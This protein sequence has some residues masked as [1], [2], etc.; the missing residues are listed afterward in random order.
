LHE[1]SNLAKTVRDH[2]NFDSRISPQEGEREVIFP[3][4]FTKEWRSHVSP[5]SGRSRIPGASDDAMELNDEGQRKFNEIFGASG[6]TLI[7]FDSAGADGHDGHGASRLASSLAADAGFFRI[8]REES[9]VAPIPATAAPQASEAFIPLGTAPVATGNATVNE[10][11]VAAVD[12]WKARR[13]IEEETARVVTAAREDAVKSGL[14]EGRKAGYD[15]GY[16]EGFKIGEEK[17][18]ISSRQVAG[19]FFGRAGELIKEFEGL[20]GHILDNVQQ[21]FFDLCQAMGEALL[22]REFEIHPEAF[23]TIMRKAVSE[24]VK[25]D[26]FT[27]RVN[28]ATAEQW[29]RL[30]FRILMPTW[31]K[32]LQCQ[33]GSSSWSRN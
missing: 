5:G 4:D 20:K 3:R 2:P 15:K 18:E 12:N 21:N 10:V 13:E 1:P 16:E 11:E 22:E 8:N 27:I 23:V 24:T 32:M 29:R 33:L 30:V 7:H 26:Q 17:G 31:S 25:G 9:V 14:E 19:Q 28:P 6:G